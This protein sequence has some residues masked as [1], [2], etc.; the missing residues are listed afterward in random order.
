LQQA[1]R[2]F[3]DPCQSRSWSCTAGRFQ[4]I[5]LVSGISAQIA[6]RTGLETVV[7]FFPTEVHFSDKSSRI[8]VLRKMCWHC[9]VLR[10][11]DGTVIP[12]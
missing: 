5:R 8:T 10:K 11:Q 9:E 12:R 3:R 1:G 7:L 6:V 2:D 4:R